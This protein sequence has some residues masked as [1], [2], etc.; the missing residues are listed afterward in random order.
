MSRAKRLRLAQYRRQR[1][2]NALREKIQEQ[3]LDRFYK[4]P[5]VCRKCEHVGPIHVFNFQICDEC[6]KFK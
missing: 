2:E 4:I 5:T 3:A 1:E 6:L